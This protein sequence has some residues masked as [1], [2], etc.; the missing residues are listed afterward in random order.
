MPLHARESASLSF[1]RVDAHNTSTGTSTRSRYPVDADAGF[2][3]S[4]RPKI[5]T[6]HGH[7]PSSLVPH[8]CPIHH[9]QRYQSIFGTIHAA[10]SPS[11][12]TRR[13]QMG[14]VESLQLGLPPVTVATARR[15]PSNGCRAR[16]IGD[17]GPPST[18]RQTTAVTVIRRVI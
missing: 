16:P 1:Q 17:F 5:C 9:E 15:H 11:W 2:R 12:R 4:L 6:A 13:T 14:P 18:A 8:V 7:A 10:Q 3:Y